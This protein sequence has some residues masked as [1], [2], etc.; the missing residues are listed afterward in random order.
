M[1]YDR[2]CGFSR[3]ALGAAVAIVIAAPALA[4]NTTSGI[5]GQVTDASGRPVAGATVSILHNESRSTSNALTDA[6]GRY[7]ARGLR[8]GG[9]YTITISQG[10]QTDRREG[11]FL[12][13]AETLSLD[14]Q[15]GVSTATVVVTGTALSDK[16][17]SQAMGASTNVSAREIAAYASIQRSLQDVA[18]LDPRLTQTDKDRGEISVAGQNSRYNS[19]TIDGVNISDSFGLEA[20]NLPTLKQP[21]SIDAI[22]S[23][24]VNVSNF[25]TTLKG[26]TGANINAV[27]KSGTNDFKGSVYYVFRDDS[28]SGKRYNR[29]DSSYFDPAPFKETTKG[30]TLGGPIVKDRLFFF[31][32]YEE[33]KST[34]E[35]P[36]FGPLGGTL[37][38]VGI[39]P[40]AIAGAQ[41]IAR[42]TYKIDIG[43]SDI[44]SGT[45][46]VVKDALLKLD[47]NINDQHRANLRYTKTDQTEPNFRNFNNRSLSLNSNWDNQLKTL[48][49]GVVQWFADWTPAFSTEAKL[50]SRKYESVFAL[51]SDLPQVTL[52][53]TGALPAGTPSTVAT[54]TRSLLFGTDR[55]R[56]FNVLKTDTLDAYLGANWTLGRHE[57]KFGADFADNEIFN[58][59]LQDTKGVYTFGCVNSIASFTYTF[60]AIN[61]GTAAAPQIEQ[62]VLENF[63]R[64]RPT[65][66]QVQTAVAG[67]TLD[68]GA[69]RW[70]LQNLGLFVQDTWKLNK[71]FTLSAGL[72]LDRQTTGD[73]PARNDAVALPKVAGNPATG[74]RQT[75][76]FGLDNTQT[77]DGEELVQPRIG[78]NWNLPTP[79]RM[80]LRG[81]VGLFQG[82]AASVWLTNPFSNPG[83]TTRVVGCG[84]A[85]TPG[86]TAAAVFNPDPNNQSTSFPGSSAV[87]NVDLVA[88]GTSQ[89]S[90]WKL[91][92]ALDAEIPGTALVAGFEWL[93]T[94][95]KAGLH[96]EH[97]NLG[98]A[99]RTGKDGRPL[100]YTAQAYNPACWTAGGSPVTS[101]TCQ[102]FRS[103]ALSNALFGDVVL[104]S[105]TTQG[106]GDSYTL[107]L[108]QPSRQGGLGWGVA[109]TRA[110]ATEVNPLTSSRAISNWTARSSFNPNEEVA[111]NSSYVVRDRLSA[112]M[113]WSK[114]FIGKY[115]TT[116]GMFF[117]A[118]RGKPYSWTYINDLNGD[119]QGGNDLM[120][121][122]AAPSS[123][124]VQ[125]GTDTAPNGP[126][127]QA[128]WAIVEAHPELRGS[129]GGTTKRN[130]SFAPFANSF[131]M[132][133]SQ[134]LPGFLPQHK[135]V[136]AL[137]ILNLGN[138][139]NKRWGRVDEVSF[140]TAAGGV[141]R[142]FVNYGGLDSQGRYI[143]HI[144]SVEDFITKQN[145]GESQWA[146]QVTLRY[147]F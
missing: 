117:E 31:G 41:A 92:L 64:G 89:P 10:G 139:I 72:R 118:R 60:G 86:C 74:A 78:F 3:T 29:T 5:A 24:Q 105:K 1:S 122:P 54:G 147:E 88:Q 132:R 76:G 12:V 114:A 79:S 39:T 25:D 32:S 130:G 42:D 110:D 73:R 57:L 58:A 96:Y 47:W 53:F 68:D 98:E 23:V 144:G 90:V 20:N 8:V 102:G 142:S 107:S 119:G 37:T 44:P 15:L 34:R 113:T 97:L 126:T 9:P 71:D 14:A 133:I 91:N 115:R 94:R 100:F 56:H 67:R 129:K 18:R 112:N 48:E 7:A 11:V 52:S 2:F 62:A 93:N 85:G 143:Y 63:Q 135:A 43:S 22:Q 36:I 106:K 111:A 131:D 99:T 77:I 38:N 28:M 46:L 134:E 45:Q 95:T 50:S 101:A 13:L 125:F 137:D 141:S 75:G 35:V 121:I 21:I 83:V 17:N 140:V 138:M 116:L 109:Y 120:Y 82:A 55:F 27:T 145:R 124:E 51:N 104:A 4:Q 6:D 81:G 127:E 84:I 59:F 87:A 40:S 65:N 61:C 136:V 19:I 26:F 70:T 108:S 123:G 80:Q 49:T 69:A 16:F 30:F 128:F 33:L 103:R 146:V 66:Y